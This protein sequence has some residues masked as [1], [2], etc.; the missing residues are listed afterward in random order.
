M[1]QALDSELTLPNAM[2]LATSDESGV[3]LKLMIAL[4]PKHLVEN[5]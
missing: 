1:E 5:L 3:N 4:M 2:S